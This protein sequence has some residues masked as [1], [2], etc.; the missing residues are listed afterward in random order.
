MSD[1]IT[2]VV[3]FNVNETRTQDFI[4]WVDTNTKN[5]AHNAFFK[6]GFYYTR[7]DHHGMFAGHCALRRFEG[8]LEA[9]PVDLFLIVIAGEIEITDANS[10]VTVLKSR[11]T[12]AVPRG[13][14]C[15][16]KQMEDARIFFMLYAGPSAQIEHPASLQVI[17]PSLQD[18]LNPIS[19]PAPELITSVPHPTVGRKVIY[20]DP[21]GQFTVGLWEASAY[22]RKLAAFTDYELMYLVEGQV[23]ITNA[24][25]ES[26]L[27]RAQEP[28]IIERGVSNAWKSQ[29]HVR[30]VYCKF[31]PAS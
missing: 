24:I 27:Y 19:G 5:L 17:V 10:R 18:T 22:T 4:P 29:G 26:H 30:K 20:V 14:S 3:S 1:S 31:S 25:G 13:L 7:A 23:E 15:V 16:W 12:V 6:S 2:P 9:F 8:V 28:F 11:D 21:T